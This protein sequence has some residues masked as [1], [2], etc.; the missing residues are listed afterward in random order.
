LLVANSSSKFIQV[1]QQVTKATFQ[2]PT[3]TNH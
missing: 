2:I 3:H 1:Y